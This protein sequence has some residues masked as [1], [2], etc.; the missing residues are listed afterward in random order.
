MQFFFEILLFYLVR[1]QTQVP[2]FSRRGGWDLDYLIDI[3]FYF[4]AG[5]VDVL[6]SSYHYC[7]E[8]QI[9]DYH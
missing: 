7:Y 8:K 1:C 5:V 9:I 3:I 4:P 2:S 6:I